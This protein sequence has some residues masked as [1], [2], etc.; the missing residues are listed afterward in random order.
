[1]VRYFTSCPGRQCRIGRP[2]IANS[3]L[4]RAWTVPELRKRTWDDLHSLWWVCVK[5]RNRLAT[6]Q[7]I[8]ERKKTD[9]G[10]AEAKGRNETVCHSMR[11]SSACTGLRCR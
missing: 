8:R 6:E 7:I 5:E 2:A 11:L 10:H 1:M 9:Y 4:G 3:T